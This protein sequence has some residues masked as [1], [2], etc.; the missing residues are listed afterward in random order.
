L[1]P[2]SDFKVELF[3]PYQFK[4]AKI[5][6][7]SYTLTANYSVPYGLWLA[8]NK[9]GQSGYWTLLNKEEHLRMPHVFMLEPYQ[10]N[11]KIIVMVHGLASS[12]ETWI[13]LTNN[14]MG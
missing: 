10:P 5:E 3:N 6:S 14:I 13:G 4:K 12:P 7:Q 11:K 9:L 8:E 1:S 2:Q